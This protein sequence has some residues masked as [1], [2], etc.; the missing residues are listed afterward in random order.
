[1][2]LPGGLDMHVY[3]GYNG[4]HMVTNQEKLDLTF[5]ALADSTRRAILSR[6]SEGEAT[7]GELARPFEISRPAIS[8]HL[9]VLENAGL[10]QRTVDGR[11]GRCELDATPMREAADWVNYYR[12]FWEGRLDA[13]ARYFNEG[14]NTGEQPASNEADSAGPFPKSE[15]G[16]SENEH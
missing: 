16:E 15:R 4:N 3:C 13:L 2:Y 1:M 5:G 14:R 7:V 11:V 12:K 6:L 10:V 9:R 8:K